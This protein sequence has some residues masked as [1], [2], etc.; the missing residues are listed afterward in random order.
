MLN[1]KVIDIL[2]TLTQEE[3][4][5]FNEFVN[6]P[7]HNKNKKVILLFNLL[8]KHHPS[9]ENK[10]LTKEN[11]FSKIFTGSEKEF[12]DAS[13]RNLLSDLMILAEK[14]LSYHGF[15]KDTFDFYEKCLKETVDRKLTGIFDKKLKSIYDKIDSE[16]FEGEEQFY[17][18]FLLEQLK[19]SSIQFSDNL[20]LYKD[21]SNTNASEYLTYFYLVK[22]FKMINFFNYQKQYNVSQN[23]NIA[24][25][26]INEIDIEEIIENLKDKSVKNYTIMTVYLKMYKALTNPD[27]DEYYYEYKKILTGNDSMFSLL[28]KYGLYVCL[29]NCCVQKIDSGNEKFFKE[30]FGVYLIMFGK[31]L[32]SA[33]PGY[34][35]MSAY[36][37]VIVTGLAANEFKK[38]E[39]LIYEYSD[40]LNPEY[41]DNAMSYS[42]AQLN[43]YTKNYDKALEFIAK[44]D[45]EFSIFK[46][47]LKILTLKIF[48]EQEDYDS[49]YYA[50]DS[51]HH[52]INKN[53]MVRED[54]KLEY[55]NFLMILDT[56]V[57]YKLNKDEKHHYKIKKNLE[58]KS[59]AGKRW[60]KEKFT[61]LLK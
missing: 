11:L 34:F 46:F 12:S 23:P 5:R 59:V 21:E 26:I 52:F 1:S 17:K 39:E 3:L 45:T 2:K 54:V 19:S 6:S 60:L 35:P 14:F 37:A 31:N 25:K 32:F 56:L 24:G 4:K 47:H 58:N 16:E 10:E 13:I 27:N 38:V 44:T 28:E 50:A 15:E 57:K 33:Y 61:Q 22:V 29:T 53:K 48:Y 49:L 40:K 55:R 9:Y 41:K 20:K 7:Y 8:S 36:N 42:L 30:C 18:K 43:F 51:F